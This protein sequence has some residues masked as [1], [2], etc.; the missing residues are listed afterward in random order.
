[1]R[2]ESLL[3]T[4][5][6]GEN[7]RLPQAEGNRGCSIRAFKEPYFAAAYAAHVANIAE[8]NKIDLAMALAESRSIQT[9]ARCSFILCSPF[10]MSDAKLAV[11][12]M[13]R[14]PWVSRTEE[15]SARCGFH[16]HATG[17]SSVLH[18][19]IEDL[20]CARSTLS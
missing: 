7:P 8:A 14:A 13:A 11:G 3:V 18:C 12:F 5:L 19:C 10:G 1:M 15:Y 2:F 6:C 20:Q 9:E 16:A 17:F 4:L